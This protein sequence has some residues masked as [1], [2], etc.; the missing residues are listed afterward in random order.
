VEERVGVR[1]DRL[2]FHPHLNPLPSRK[3]KKVALKA[4]YLHTQN[5]N[6]GV[7]DVLDEY[8]VFSFALS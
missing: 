1:G 3:R 2:R 4:L 7:T 8:R 5:N 6:E